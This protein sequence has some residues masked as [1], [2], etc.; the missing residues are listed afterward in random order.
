[1]KRDLVSLNARF[2]PL[3]RFWLL[4]VLMLGSMVM[5]LS[6]NSINVALTAIID[7]FMM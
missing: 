6:S 4:G 3:Y 7:E 5:V 2:G 1:M